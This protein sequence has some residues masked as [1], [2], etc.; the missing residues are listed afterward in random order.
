MSGRLRFSIRVNNDLSVEETVALAK[1]AEAAGFDQFWLSHDLFMRSAPV[2]LAVA[3]QHTERIHLGIGILNPYTLDPA[4]IAMVAATLSEVTGGRFLLGLAPGAVEFLD[5]VGLEQ[6]LA[7]TRVRETM[8]VLRLLLEGKRA[9]FEGRTLRWKDGAYLRMPGATVPIYLG[10]M[11]PRMLELAGRSADGVLPLLFPPE[12][13]DTVKPLVD[14][15]ARERE[16]DLAALDFAACVW[17]S[18]DDDG[19]LARRVLAA[20]IAYYGASLGS[21]ILERLGVE[22]AE[23]AELARIA[24]ADGHAERAAGLVTDDMMA[25]G[26]AGGPDEV[27]VRLERLVAL[28]ARHLSFGPP[29]GP[30]PLRA[31]ELL[32]REVLPKLQGGAGARA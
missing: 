7:L 11:G 26:I 18:L 23:F 27:V 8:V 17:I 15:G 4:E 31:V 5:W 21:L 24:T 2:A 3:A 9:A 30:E 16:P 14:R 1:G 25:I 6:P 20:K 29:L 12:H 32:G 19:D 10:A 22:A 13:F 28:G